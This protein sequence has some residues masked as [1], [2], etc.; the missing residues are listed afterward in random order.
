MN[1][2]GILTGRVEPI[3]QAQPLLFATK[4][5]FVSRTTLLDVKAAPADRRIQANLE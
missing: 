2:A 1:F 3:S 4:I 5:A